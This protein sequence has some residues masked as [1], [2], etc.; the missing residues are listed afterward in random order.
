[1][2]RALIKAQRGGEEKKKHRAD[3]EAREIEKRKSKKRENVE[4]R[5]HW[6]GGKNN[7]DDEEL[8]RKRK[9]HV[10]RRG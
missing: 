7:D 3:A 2:I 4:N 5:G 1:M 10:R 9:R 6:T 8:R